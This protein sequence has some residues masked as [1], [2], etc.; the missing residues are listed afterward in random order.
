LDT[1]FCIEDASD[2]INWKPNKP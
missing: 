1:L 2:L